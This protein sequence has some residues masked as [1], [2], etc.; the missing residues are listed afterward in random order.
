MIRKRFAQHFLEPAW[1]RKLVD[2]IAPEPTDVIFEI[3][4]G[5]GAVTAALAPR[6]RSLTTIEIDRDLAALLRRSALPNVTVVEGDVLR[7]DLPRLFQ[8]LADQ[9]GSDGRV[10]LVGNLPYNISSPILFRLMTLVRGGAALHDATVMLQREVAD[11]VAGRP[12]TGDWGPLSIAIQLRADVIRQLALPPGAFRPTPRVHS[13]VL[14]L[15]FHPM[16]V[17][18]DDEGM[19]D[20]VVRAVFGQ[21]RK[22]LL[23]ALRPF[24]STR[25]LSSQQLLEAAGIESQRR[26]QTLSLDEFARLADALGSA[27]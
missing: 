4:P 5:R 3:G 22:T 19:L 21:R 24:A 7:A 17:A 18:V 12:G 10:R 2:A 15:R 27:V 25:G 11:R 26:P 13:T 20:S 1:V 8:D 6:V 23:N 9:A 16:V 14:R